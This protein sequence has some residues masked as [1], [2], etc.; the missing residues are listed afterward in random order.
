MGQWKEYGLWDKKSFLSPNTFT[1]PFNRIS[2]S[3][4]QLMR[5]LKASVPLLQ[6]G[7]NIL[8]FTDCYKERS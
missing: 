6:N 5:T 2:D 7:H 8:H 3:I 4:G 1:L